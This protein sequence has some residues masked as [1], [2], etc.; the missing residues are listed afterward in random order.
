[1]DSVTAHD[2]QRDRALSA[3]WTAF[4]EARAIEDRVSARHLYHAWTIARKGTIRG[5]LFEFRRFAINYL[6]IMAPRCPVDLASHARAA[7]AW[8]TAI[9]LVEGVRS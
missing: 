8:A 5:A 7:A 1:M 4:E 3:L 6:T 2:S 9:A